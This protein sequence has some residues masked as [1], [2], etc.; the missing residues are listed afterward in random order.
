MDELRYPKSTVPIE[1]FL[2]NGVQLNLEVFV[3]QTQ[4]KAP[5]RQY[6]I[7]LLEDPLAF[8]PAR[9]VDSQQMLFVNKT[10]VV[11]AKLKLQLQNAFEDQLFEKQEKV[12]IHL[13]AKQVLEGI[14]L[15]SSPADRSRVADYFNQSGRFIRLW[16]V[17]DLFLVNKNNIYSIE[18]IT[19][20]IQTVEN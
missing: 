5:R 10:N 15:Y 16:T 9:R 3:A 17:Q 4:D 8:L 14:V 7:D 12:R 6:V 20:E 18:E 1:L 2:S 19:G 13:G 11:W